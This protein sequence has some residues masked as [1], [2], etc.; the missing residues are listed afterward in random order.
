M[1]N[2][3][4]EKL[5]TNRRGIVLMECILVLPIYLAL[6]GGLFWIGDMGQSRN[7]II[8]GEQYYSWNS[9][10]RHSGA[11]SGNI[12]KNRIGETYFDNISVHKKKS[13]SD[14][15]N[16]TWDNNQ[17]NWHQRYACN[18]EV[19][20][21]AWEMLTSMLNAVYI[22]GDDPSKIGGKFMSSSSGTSAGN[23]VFS[24]RST[25][26]EN[27]SYIRT[28]SVLMR[29]HYN[30]GMRE[31][32][33][34]YGMARNDNGELTKTILT[35]NFIYPASGDSNGTIR[36]GNTQAYTRYPQYVEWS[37]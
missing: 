3:R 34:A 31:R 24:I 4:L 21:Q 7:K 35:K 18:L 37:N 15:Y 14:L 5:K 1:K 26:T 10:M 30:N 33:T 27:P 12:A 19:K 25:Y 11:A 9:G 17:G 22:F 32:M 13:I 16:S 29:S 20:F 28:N 23:E 6:L 2:H 8:C 36:I